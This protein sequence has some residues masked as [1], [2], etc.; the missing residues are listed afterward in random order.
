MCKGMK[1]T[2]P[3]VCL[4]GDLGKADPQNKNMGETE[5]RVGVLGALMW[6]KKNGS[7]DSAL[8]NFTFELS[9]APPL[10]FKPPFQTLS[11]GAGWILSSVQSW[12]TQDGNSHA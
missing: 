6:K 7:N 8:C 12:V 1:K 3:R 11:V 10:Y 9:P 5:N 4:C 2:G